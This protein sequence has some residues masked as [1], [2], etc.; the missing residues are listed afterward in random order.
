M[1]ALKI[2]KCAFWGCG[3][4]VDDAIA[5]NH[6]GIGIHLS[7]PDP[8]GEVKEILRADGGGRAPVKFYIPVGHEQVEVT[9]KEK[10]KLSG[11]TRLAFLSVPG[12]DKIT[13]I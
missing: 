12:I 6:A 10:F 9:V 13:E 2:V 4:S 3:Q 11:D 1:R 8:I 5:A 7:T